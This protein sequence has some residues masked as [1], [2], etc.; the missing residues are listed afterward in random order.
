M[1]A[2][3]VEEAGEHGRGWF[4]ESF[5]GSPVRVHATTDVEMQAAAIALRLQQDEGLNTNYGTVED[6]KT[7]GLAIRSSLRYAVLVLEEAS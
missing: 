6:L 2:V 3:G 1:T 5:R 7:E 4:V